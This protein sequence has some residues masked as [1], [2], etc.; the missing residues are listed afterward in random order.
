MINRPSY[1]SWWFSW[2]GWLSR[3]APPDN[4]TH[5]NTLNEVIISFSR[6]ILSSISAELRIKN[7]I[8]AHTEQKSA[9]EH[10]DEVAQR[11]EEM[12][13][14]CTRALARH[15]LSLPQVAAVSPSIDSA[16]ATI[17]DNACGT[18]VVTE[19]S[20]SKGSQAQF[21][22]V[23]AAPNMVE[24]AKAKLSEKTNVQYGVMPGE[25]LEFPDEHF[26]HSFTNLGILFFKSPADGAKEL[27][28]T[29]KPGGIAI[30]TS[31]S[32]F[33]TVED[34]VIPAQMAVHPEDTPFKLPVPAE[35]LEPGNLERCL[36]DDGG[37]TKV[38]MG[39]HRVVYGASTKRALY[40]LVFD[41][42][43]DL[44]LK[45]WSEEDAKKFAAA[46]EKIVEGSAHECVL[47]DG[48]SGFGLPMDGIIAICHK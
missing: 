33:G 14:G 23:D 16:D 48:K 32:R 37:F 17:L 47:N 28:R 15:I 5:A 8:M 26:T 6:E 46:L 3:F 36:R 24:L 44:A 45:G 40:E 4:D 22:A 34:A 39:A 41:S 19:E 43:K 13:G 10:F 35:W 18:A 11:Y 9:A 7:I 42:Y 2:L 12:T 38:E 27:R 29:L 1:A 30:I 31:W 25:V 20:L 21:Y